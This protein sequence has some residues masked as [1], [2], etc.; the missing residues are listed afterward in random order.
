MDIRRVVTI[1]VAAA[2]LAGVSVFAQQNNA[3]PNRR[4]QEKRSQQEQRDIQALVQLVDAVAAGKQP[5]P[6]DVSVTWAGN[7]FVKGAADTTFIPFTVT[8]DP[9]TLTAPGVALYVRAVSKNAAP[10]PAPAPAPANSRDRNQQPAAPVY[11]W[12]DI[13]FLDVPQGGK[14]SRAMML[15]PGEYD[16]FI[17]IKEKTPAQLPRN[18][19]PQK[20]GLLR[21]ALMVPDFNGPELTISTPIIA[22]SVMPLA[23]P[24]S[25]DA[26]RANPYT[27]G[28]TLQVVPAADSQLKT[29]DDLQLLF[30]IYGVQHANG[31]PDVLV[32]F[33]FHQKT[34]DSEKFFNKT[35]PQ[36][37]NQ[38]TLPP[39]FNITAGHQV[40]G[41]LGVPLKSFPAGEYRVEIKITDKLSG[42]TLTHNAT[43][44]VEA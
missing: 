24:L 8:I 40:L 30:W 39:G 18:A 21:Q 15:K 23:S 13:Q 32:E 34:G 26:Q 31:V 7:H 6:A 29:S 10:A 27:F 20:A 2:S 1:V 16:L 12:D 9:S 35:Q 36:V 22:D 4:E 43:F 25:P 41:F 14:V 11:P 37:L 19:P 17:A 28:G 44:T 3:Q 33:N 5:A 42:K 38:S